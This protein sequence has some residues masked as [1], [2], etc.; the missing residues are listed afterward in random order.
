MHSIGFGT[1]QLKKDDCYNSVLNALKIGYRLID[2]ATLYKNHNEVGRAIKDSGI[3]RNDIYIT[4]KVH[5]K[6]IESDTVLDSID[7]ILKELQLDYVDMLLLHKPFPTKNKKNW[8]DMIKIKNSGKAKNIGISNF[9]ISDIIEILDSEI[10]PYVNQIEFSPLCQRTNLVKFCF[11]NNI[12]VQA[13]RSFGLNRCL[14]NEIINKVAITM[15]ITPAQVILLWTLKKG[16]IIIPSTKCKIQMN[17]N[18][19]VINMDTNNNELDKLDS[20]NED[21]YT[22]PKYADEK[23]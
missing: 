2:T 3:D 12:K 16:I 22:M 18:I 21:Y 11:K 9:C 10:I 13:Y 20:I 6:Y 19:A 15:G 23:Y 8:D 7:I 17:E 5:F 4:S 1:Y 14:E